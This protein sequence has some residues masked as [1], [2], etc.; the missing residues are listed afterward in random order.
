MK[1]IKKK[2]KTKARLTHTVADLKSLKQRITTKLLNKA[3]K[4]IHH[5]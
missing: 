2:Q 5:I 4:I 3:L 1:D